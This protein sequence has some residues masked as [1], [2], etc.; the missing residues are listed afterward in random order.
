M[1]FHIDVIFNKHFL[2]ST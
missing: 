1:I 2:L